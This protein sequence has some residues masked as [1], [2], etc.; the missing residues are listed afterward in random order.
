M[1]RITL[2]WLVVSFFSVYAFRDWFKSLCILILLMAIVQHPDFPNSVMGVQG[3]NPWNVL[4]LFIGIAWLTARRRE[5]LVF[6]MQPKV[7]WLLFFFYLVI[8][9]SYVRVSENIGELIEFA[10][11]TNANPPTRLGLFSEYI[12]NCLKWIVPGILLYD[13]CNSKQRFKLAL[14]CILTVYVLLAIQVIRWMPLSSFGGGAELADHAI[15]ILSDNIG[16]HR[17][18]LSMLLAGASWAIYCTMKYADTNR[19]RMVAIGSIAIVVLGQALTG[20]RMGYGAWAVL[21]VMFGVLRWRW[22]LVVAPAAAAV[23]VLVV[24]AVKERLQQGFTE[25]SI[26]S[27]SIE[28]YRLGES[29]G[30]DFYTVT[31]GRTFAWSFV[32][33]EIVKA[34]LVGY[35]RNSM[36]TTGIGPH[37][38]LEYQESF[39]HPHNSYLE[40]TLDNGLIGAIP[41]FY[42]FAII[43][44]RSKRLFFAK[45]SNVCMTIGGVTLALVGAFL[46]AGMGSQTFYPREGSVGMWCSISLMLR[47]Y[48][49]YINWKPEDGESIDSSESFWQR[50]ATSDIRR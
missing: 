36:I 8:V 4:M 12:I 9:V 45:E 2:L 43:M 18:N 35:G 24:P 6:D 40:W 46:I 17:V 31:S 44:L 20:G 11:W 50:G 41:V 38:F 34:P 37:L 7:F 15:K 29:D 22:M 5:G 47:V 49:Q 26:D 19:F 23:V 14:F 16:M 42:L 3:F 33:D 48:Q 21:A 25:D 32:A 28:Y 30:P 13:G 27:S 10:E 1:I 39:P